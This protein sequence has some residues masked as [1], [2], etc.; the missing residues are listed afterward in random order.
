[1]IDYNELVRLLRNDGVILCPSDTVA[2]LSC[3]ALSSK[4]LDR[5]FEIKQRPAHKS[6]IVLVSSFTMLEAYVPHIPDAAYQL[7]ETSDHP[8][9]VVYPNVRNLPPL[10]IADDGSAGIRMVND[11]FIKSLVDRLKHPIISTSA[12]VSGAVTPVRITEVSDEIS[13]KVDSIIDLPEFRERPSSIIKFNA[14]NSFTI[15]RK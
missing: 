3:S 6:V 12:N 4:A 15:I 7:I 11:G 5:I 9:T 10:A 2:S 13:S 8:T 1:M 14:D